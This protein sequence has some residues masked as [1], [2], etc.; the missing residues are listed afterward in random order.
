MA[1]SYASTS[2]TTN[3]NR[4][5]RT[6][7]GPCTDGLRDVL[8]HYV[9]PPTFPRVIKLNKLNLPRL[10]PGQR[11]LILPKH[12]TY[13]GNY[14]D[15][16]ISLLYI[17]LR[18]ITS[19]TP[20]SNGWGN[21]PHHSDSSLSANIER[22]RIIRNSC[23]HS[24][25]PFMSNTDFNS[26]WS[27]MRS[28]MVDLDTFLNNSNHYEKEVDFLR[29]ETMDPDRDLRYDQE[30]RKQVEEDRTTREMVNNMKGKSKFFYLKI[31]RIFLYLNQCLGS[32]VYHLISC[33]TDS[34]A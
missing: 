23:V 3:A 31:I 8:H 24:S 17:L 29:H 21:D 13:T 18:N 26:I 19:I 16:D 30:L 22:I 14:S 27:T 5:S 6:V 25:V 2:E 11:D 33:K 1:S 32:F 20:H 15:M 28:T 7:L 12:G 34:R 10:T 9:P 4:V